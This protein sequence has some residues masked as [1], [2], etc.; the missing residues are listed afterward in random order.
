MQNCTQQQSHFVDVFTGGKPLITRWMEQVAD[1]PLID[2]VC[3]VV[4]FVVGIVFQQISHLFLLMLLL[5]VCFSARILISI[6]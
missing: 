6:V 5:F 1:V 2:G 4:R 3:V